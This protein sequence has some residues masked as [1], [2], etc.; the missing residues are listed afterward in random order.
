M[1]EE[2]PLLTIRR[3]IPRPT[4]AQIE[5][6]RSCTSGWIVDAQEGRASLGPSVRSI[7]PDVPGLARAVGTALTC[8]CGPNDN[9]AILA[10]LELAAP[11]DVIVAATEAFGRSGVVGD[12]VAGMMRNKGIAAFVT[13]GYVRDL[14][15]LREAGLPIFAAGLVP[16]SCV[17]SGPGTVGM[18]I[19]IGNRAI[20]SGDIIVADTDGVTTVPLARADE[21]IARLTAVKAAESE[22]LAKVR[23]G[24]KG[25]PRTA[26][27]LASDRVR[28]VD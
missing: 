7:F 28:F 24:I 17:K 27:L 15:G 22:M 5:A 25:L 18:P 4:D 8:W 16:D 14:I 10:A 1:I 19:V 11:G 2:P 9:L 20:A 12:L 21:I 23:G 13:D 26:D 6:V 3:N